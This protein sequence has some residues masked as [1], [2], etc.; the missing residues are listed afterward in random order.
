[1]F[2]QALF[3]VTLATVSLSFAAPPGLHAILQ[4]EDL[5]FPTSPVKMVGTTAGDGE[6]QDYK[7][8]KPGETASILTVKGP[9]LIHRIWSTSQFTDQTKLVVKL[10]GKEQPLWGKA[11][12]P[13][14]QAANDPLRAMD[15]QA[16]WSYIPVKVG[17]S[18]EFV[19]TDLRKPGGSTPEATEPN[20]FYLQVAY[21]AGHEGALTGAELEE[22]RQRLRLYT[23]NPFAGS[24]DIVVEGSAQAAK[25]ETITVTRKAPVSLSGDS[26]SFVQAM[27][28]DAGELEF[29]KLSRT[30]LVIRPAGS[31]DA[32]VDVPVPALFC[33]FWGMDEYAGPITAIAKNKLVFRLP[34]PIGKGL[35]LQLDSFGGDAAADVAITIVRGT[36]TK[37]IPYTFCAEYREVVSEKGKPITLAEVPGEGVFVGCTFAGGA[38]HHRKFAFLEGNEQIYVDGEEKPSWEGT[39]TEDFFNGAWYFSAGVQSRP[40]HGLTHLDEGPPPQMSA[41]RYLIPDRIAF[42]KGIRVDMQHGSRN[43]V[44]GI[45]YKSV[46]FWYQAGPCKVLEPS[47]AT[48]S[49]GGPEGLAAGEEDA[50]APLDVVTPAIL[51][52]VAALFVLA[53]VRFILR[54]RRER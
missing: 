10:D 45:T 40:F 22:V 11:A 49:S 42:S 26:K 46:A 14:G 12:L 36:A 37:E 9:C 20:K 35:D 53:L 29:E 28:I 23:S 21:S 27:I 44:P 17:V 47:E 34:I 16:Y 38:T 19:A 30:R 7:P 31:K 5:L 6:G 2:R 8:L 50:G 15:G 41:Y 18:A 51:A 54:G 24:P 13:E 25:S 4:P 32:C 33:S 48:E 52:V 1:M 43:S 39:G 3:L